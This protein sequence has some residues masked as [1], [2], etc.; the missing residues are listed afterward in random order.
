MALVGADGGSSLGG[1]G[2]ACGGKS[3]EGG[4]VSL[5]RLGVTCGGPPVDGIT[6]VAD[7]LERECKVWFRHG[8]AAVGGL[9]GEARSDSAS[10]TGTNGVWEV[11]SVASGCMSATMTIE[12]G[13]GGG[14]GWTKRGEDK[15]RDSSAPSSRGPGP[16]P[17][18]QAEPCTGIS[19]Q[20][21]LGL[22]WTC[23]STWR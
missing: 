4:G 17:P 12:A 19:I 13:P 21:S 11:T 10:G 6:S 16:A 22:A 20:E 2:A 8:D 1:L 5:E 7:G 23:S 14:K 9:I 15:R 3:A 18:P